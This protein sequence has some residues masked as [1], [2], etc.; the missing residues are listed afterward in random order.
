MDVVPNSKDFLGEFIASLGGE[1]GEEPERV[2]A[3]AAAVSVSPS[4]EE[5][6]ES[7]VWMDIEEAL[8]R[9]TERILDAESRREKTTSFRE[10][11]RSIVA[12]T[13]ARRIY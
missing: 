4:P 13:A 2:R 6:K 8:H 1:E 7:N 11:Y 5:V 9:W 12:Q 3:P 10:K